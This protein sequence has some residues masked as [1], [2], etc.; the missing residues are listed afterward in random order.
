MRDEWLF[1][2]DVGDRVRIAGLMQEQAFVDVPFIPLGQI[3]P[4]TV[5]NRSVRNVLQGY[6][7]FWNLQ[8]G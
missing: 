7:L 1:A 2:T 6:A 3:L 8:K 5:Y 4:P